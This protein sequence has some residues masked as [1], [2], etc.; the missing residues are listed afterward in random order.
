MSEQD[1]AAFFDAVKKH[2]EKLEEHAE[3]KSR[4]AEK[5]MNFEQRVRSL[6]FALTAATLLGAVAAMVTI[7][8]QFFGRDNGRALIAQAVSTGDSSK[9]ATLEQLN[10]LKVSTANAQAVLDSA[11][12][13]LGQTFDDRN[14]V[15][16]VFELTSLRA[17]VEQ[18][19]SRLLVLER[20]I[21]DNPEKALSIPMLRKDQE[22]MAKAIEGNKL[23]VSS[24]LSRIYDQQKWILGGVATILFALVTA[25]FSALFKM[26]FKTKENES[27]FQD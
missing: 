18:I 24:D 16:Q 22:N 6:K 14:T 17:S 27:A 19:D 2:Q 1:N 10:D 26:V 20:S 9:F 13:Q 3:Y 7:T 25:L 23:A 5:T 11:V 8:S 12:K 15:S 21:S 4:L